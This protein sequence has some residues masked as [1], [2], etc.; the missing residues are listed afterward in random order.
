MNAKKMGSSI[1][2]GLAVGE[3]G[4]MVEKVFKIKSPLAG[5]AP[6]VPDISVHTFGDVLDRAYCIPLVYRKTSQSPWEARRHAYN[7]PT[8]RISIKPW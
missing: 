2:G 1:L 6:V 8:F 3:A 4:N 5:D 7:L